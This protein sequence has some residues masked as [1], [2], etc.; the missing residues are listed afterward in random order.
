[1]RVYDGKLWTDNYGTLTPRDIQRIER[2]AS[3]LGELA[4]AV[5]GNAVDEQIVR[6]FLSEHFSLYWEPDV[7][8]LRSLKDEG[9]EALRALRDWGPT[10]D[11]QP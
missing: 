2:M 8:R 3:R 11:T 4:D 6:D 10:S 1:M 9:E 7:D 5:S